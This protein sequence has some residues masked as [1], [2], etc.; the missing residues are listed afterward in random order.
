TGEE[1]GLLGSKYFAANPTVPKNSFVADINTDMFLPI[2]PLKLLTVYGLDESSLGDTVRQVAEQQ[3][4]QVQA[5][6][7]PLRNSFIRSDQYSFIRQ[8]IPSVAMKV[9]FKPGS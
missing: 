7:E 2:F 3:G 4:V 6:P 5:D 8:G 1:K 9:G